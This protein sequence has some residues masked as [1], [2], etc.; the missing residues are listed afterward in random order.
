M[1]P[2]RCWPTRQNATMDSPLQSRRVQA[3][4]GIDERAGVDRRKAGTARSHTDGVRRM[5]GYRNCGRHLLDQLAVVPIR[6]ADVHYLPRLQNRRV[7][8]VGNELGRAQ[9]RPFPRALQQPNACAYALPAHSPLSASSHAGS[10]SVPSGLIVHECRWFFR[11]GGRP[12]A[13]EQSGC[14]LGVAR[15]ELTATLGPQKRRSTNDLR[16]RTT[17]A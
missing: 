7:G 13:R 4:R 16:E 3:L 15:R 11:D 1:K 8:E 14:I 5:P 17:E 6:L 10:L 2:A 9:V 12:E